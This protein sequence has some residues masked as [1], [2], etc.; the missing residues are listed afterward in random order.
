MTMTTPKNPDG[1]PKQALTPSGRPTIDFKAMVDKA[2]GDVALA[3][4]VG[5]LIRLMGGEQID[6]ERLGIRDRMDV[7]KFLTGRMVPQLESHEVTTEQ[8]GLPPP[9]VISLNVSPA[10][11]LQVVKA[12]DE[13]DKNTVVDIVSDN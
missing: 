1:S 10:E 2:R 8:K 5:F 6:G 7:A 9:L 4:P 3:N 12:Q 13:R 11:S